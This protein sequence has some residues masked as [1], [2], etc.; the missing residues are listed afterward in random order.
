[1]ATNTNSPFKKGVTEKH[2][3]IILISELNFDDDN[4]KLYGADDKEYF[5]SLKGSIRDN[6]LKNPIL[7]YPDTNKVKSGHARTRACSSLGYTHIPYTYS[8]S[9]VPSSEYEN[10][11]SLQME[12]QTRTANLKRQYNQIVVTIEAWEEKHDKIITQKIIKEDICVAAQMSYYTYD[13]L[14]KLELGRPDL[15]KRVIESNGNALSPGKAVE[16]MKKDKKPPTIMGQSKVM[17]EAITKDDVTYAVNAVSHAMNTLKTIQVNSRDGGKISAFDNIQQNTIGGLVHEV[18]TN[19]LSHSINHRY[20]KQNYTIAFPPKSHNDEDIQFE[21]YNGG[22]EVKTCLIKDGTKVRFVCKNP[23]IGYFMF[24]GFSPDYD[25]VYVA[26][27]QT[28]EKVWNKAGRAFA[29]VNLEELAKA[30]LD[31][32][33]G[34]LQIDKSQNKTKV[35]CYSDKLGL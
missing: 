24:A 15:F 20:Q 25:R 28:D 23:K 13:L 30:G 3:G 21:L 34:S 1:M 10:M 26:Y 18:F 33:Y 31:T 17:E 8:I 19:S 27:G 32:Y 5:E 6:G 14:D 11:M 2:D 9:D 29:N 12:N 35:N 22:I 4:I 7:I 16:L